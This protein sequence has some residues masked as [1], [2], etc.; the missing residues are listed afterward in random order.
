MSTMLVKQHAP[1]VIVYSFTGG[2]NPFPNVIPQNILDKIKD[3]VSKLRQNASQF[4]EIISKYLRE[5][6]EVVTF[7]KGTALGTALG[8]IVASIVEDIITLGAGI[9]DD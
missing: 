9:A 3:L 2:T 7:I 8:I 5:H 6:P 4:K 1:G